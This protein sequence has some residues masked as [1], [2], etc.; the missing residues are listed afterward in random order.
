MG[1]VSMMGLR[2]MRRMSGTKSRRLSGTSWK[3]RMS[4]EEEWREWGFQSGSG[5][6]LRIFCAVA[7]SRGYSK[8]FRIGYCITLNH[9][10]ILNLNI[11]AHSMS[12]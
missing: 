8:V 9:R 12:P 3:R 1:F 6:T 10:R 11:M 2:R 4:R 5:S 7:I